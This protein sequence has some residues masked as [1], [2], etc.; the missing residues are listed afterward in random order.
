MTQWGLFVVHQSSAPFSRTD[1]HHQHIGRFSI[2]Q[3]RHK[4]LFQYR[5]Q[6]GI[7][8]QGASTTGPDARTLNMTSTN[9]T[10]EA[11]DA[12]TWPMKATASEKDDDSDLLKMPSV[13]N[14]YAAVEG[15][16]VSGKL[17]SRH[18]FRSRPQSTEQ[19]SDLPSITGVPP[20]IPL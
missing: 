6:H 20:C 19:R 17:N 16:P 15:L 2:S 18:V 10:Q 4:A 8:V 1:L 11:T 9:P 3:Y 5:T 12:D 14:N 7:C 13:V